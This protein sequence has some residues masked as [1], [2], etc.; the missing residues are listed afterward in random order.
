MRMLLVLHGPNGLNLSCI[1]VSLYFEVNMHPLVYILPK[2]KISCVLAY[3]TPSIMEVVCP[4]L[5]VL[6]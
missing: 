3:V 1:F 4:S 2:D 5:V 6:F